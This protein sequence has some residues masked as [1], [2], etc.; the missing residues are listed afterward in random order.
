MVL[1][2]VRAMRIGNDWQEGKSEPGDGVRIKDG[3]SPSQRA[4]GLKLCHEIRAEEWGTD[5]SKQ[6]AHGS[7]NADC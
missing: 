6:S 3:P 5:N 4:R 2:T 7:R 1:V